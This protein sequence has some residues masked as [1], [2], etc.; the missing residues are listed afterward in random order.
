MLNDLSKER[1]ENMIILD[2]VKKVFQTSSGQ[3]TAVDSVNLEIKKGE[4]F[5]IIGYSG[6]GKSTLIRM[7][8]LL[9]RPTDGTVT[10]D[11]KDLTKVS[12]KELR[13]A[14]QQIGMV[15]QH[16][17]LLWSRT[18][19]ENIVFS[20]EIAGVKKNEIKPRV[21]ELIQLVGL[22]GKENNYPSQLSGGQKQRVGIARALANNPKVLLCDEAT[23]ALDPQTT[24]EILDLLVTIN[25]KYNLTIVLITHEMHVIQK[26]CHHVAIMENGRIVEQGD[27]LTVFRTPSHSVTKRFVKQ[28]VN[29][30]ESLNMLDTLSKQF[31]DGKIVLLKYFQGNAEKPFITNVIRKYDVDINI[32]HGKVV[33]TQDGGYG[34]LYVQLTGNDINSALNYLKEAGVEIEVMAR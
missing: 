10:I 20:L 22:S 27:V 3:V 21:L 29:E 30:D 18:V 13:L 14:R 6:A 4:I 33:Q 1:G 23:S 31:P 2:Q 16:F 34:S 5:G 24:D 11:G 28:V 8:N 25:R 26:I 17:N 15:F 19:Y 7:L 9:E 12:A 32:I